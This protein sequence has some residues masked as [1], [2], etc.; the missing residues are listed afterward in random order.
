VPRIKKD[1][2]YFNEGEMF[3]LWQRRHSLS[4]LEQKYYW[5]QINAVIKA[6]I[7]THR[8]YVYGPIEDSVGY[9]QDALLAALDRYNPGKILASGK[10]PS[11]FNY[12]SLTAYRAIKY[13]TLKEKKDLLYLSSDISEYTFLSYEQQEDNDPYHTE[14]HNRITKILDKKYVTSKHKTFSHFYSLRDLLIEYLSE[15]QD[16][17]K[18]HLLA[19][20]RQQQ[21]KISASTIR[22]FFA[23]M[24]NKPV[25]NVVIRSQYKGV[26]YD[27]KTD[28]WIS[29]VYHN[30][31]KYSHSTHK[32]EVQAALAYNIKALQ[33]IGDTA[34][35]NIIEQ[36]K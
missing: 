18:R 7:F 24:Q 12:I 31:K 19:Y 2:N 9:A 16:L 1:K 29:F 32:T 28:K 13:G 20:F 6:V 15:G 5:E 36:E 4:P 3:I 35:L 25:R 11:L 22:Q 30:K 21:P 14:L 23:I 27:K 34:K 17:D 10:P 26:Y 33:I 8:M